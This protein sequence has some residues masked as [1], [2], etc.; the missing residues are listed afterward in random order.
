MTINPLVAGGK[1][2]CRRLQWSKGDIIGNDRLVTFHE[3]R[4]SN[5]GEGQ[6]CPMP[7]TFNEKSQA[8]GVSSNYTNE[9]AVG[10]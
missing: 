5:N 7:S 6:R 4:S 2:V 3:V 8:Q 9:S 10:G 1:G